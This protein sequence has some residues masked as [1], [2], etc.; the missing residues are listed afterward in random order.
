MES[1]DLFEDFG[2]KEPNENK[3]HSDKNNK[4][5]TQS[6]KKFSN[7]ILG[8]KKKREK[9]ILNSDSE[10]SQNNIENKENKENKSNENKTISNET[11]IELTSKEEDILISKQ[12]AKIFPNFTFNS[13]E[14]KQ[15]QEEIISSQINMNMNI[16]KESTEVSTK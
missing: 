2:I 10:N 8:K 3:K 13:I 11:E 12:I 14:N 9:E 15:N 5:N 4:S 1:N 7:K 16:E 6:N